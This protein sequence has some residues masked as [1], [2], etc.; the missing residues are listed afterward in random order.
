MDELMHD[1]EN[2]KTMTEYQSGCRRLF[3]AV[4]VFI[5]LITITLI[6]ILL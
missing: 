6:L 5:W 1:T 4:I 2:N 3:I